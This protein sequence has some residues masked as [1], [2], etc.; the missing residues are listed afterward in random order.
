MRIEFGASTM[1][2]FHHIY[3]CLEDMI[4]IHICMPSF[5]VLFYDSRFT[6]FSA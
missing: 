1:I 3:L 5:V 6:G 2:N 4:A